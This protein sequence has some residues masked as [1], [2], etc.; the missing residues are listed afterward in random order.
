METNVCANHPARRASLTCERCGS[1]A[2]SEC[3]VDAPWGTSVCAPCKARG[4]LSYPLPWER[5][6]P[7]NPLCFARSART[8]VVDAEHLFANLP[9]GSVLRALGFSAW[10]ALCL[11]ASTLLADATQLRFDW[12]D[13]ATQRA[14]SLY[15]LSQL[16]RQSVQTY[17]LVLLSAAGFHVVARV[18][19]GQGSA[20]LAIRAAAYGSVF[21]LFNAAT[22][23][24]GTLAP[25][26]EVAA[27]IISAIT[28]S[29]LY[30]TCLR[31]AA[32]EHYGVSRARGD[33]IAGATV[34]MLVPAMFGASLLVA[35]M[36][37]QV[38]RAAAWIMR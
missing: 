37:H 38:E 7:F 19:G 10:V 27:L 2:C 17:S 23:L 31:T 12:S 8:I 20:M 11:T 9:R 5:G 13:G 32:V 18:L 26:F 30:F 6:N 4:G 35:V 22:T 33:V 15:G 1:Y 36:S 34:G 3:A 14:L 24:T 16:I 28:Q 21:L 29:Y 25:A